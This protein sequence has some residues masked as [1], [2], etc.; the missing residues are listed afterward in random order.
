MDEAN[1]K[2]R[3]GWTI[4]GDC[5]KKG[6]TDIQLFEPAVRWNGDRGSISCKGYVQKMW[7]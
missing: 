4:C 6:D 7:L 5:R 1:A 3:G 2:C